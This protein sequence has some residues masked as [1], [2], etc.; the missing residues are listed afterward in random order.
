MLHNLVTVLIGVII[1]ALAFV[2]KVLSVSAV[3]K[4]YVDEKGKIMR[5]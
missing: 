2:L 4:K 1:S 3:K 5:F